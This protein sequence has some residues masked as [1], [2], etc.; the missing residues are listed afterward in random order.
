MKITFLIQDL[1][2]QGAQY[3][4]ALMIR[5]FAAKGYDVDLIVSKVHADLLAKGDIQP[6]EVPLSTNIITLADRKARNNIGEIRNYLKT[7]DSIAVVSMSSNYNAAL[8]IAG[9]GLRHRPKLAYVEHLGM[10]D[11]KSPSYFSLKFWKAKFFNSCFDTIMAVSSGTA[12]LV[13]KS[14]RM[15][16]GEVKVVYNPAIDI[17]YYKKREK[18]AYH[19]WLKDK[20][21]PTFIAAGSHSAIKNHQFLFEAIKLANESTP[22]RL[23]LFGKGELTSQY[24]QWIKS[25]GMEDRI[26]L[27]G[28]TSQLPAE[29]K[30]SDG[31]IISSNLESFSVVL[32]EALAANVPVIS[33]AC[34][35][36]P[37]ELLKNG[38]YGRLVPVGDVKALAA[39]II[40]QI[41]NP[42]SPAPAKA[43]QPYLLEN[44][45]SAYENALNI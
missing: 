41:K 18:E 17:D 20:S 42:R 26:N 28:H 44:V 10:P 36:G 19:H 13:E 21:I 15:K 9:T 45:V 5:G 4:T 3:V 22:V 12:H 32:V 8:A 40:D 11:C 31:L 33:T 14:A 6:F 37:P 25:T 34:P 27:A 35:F 16:M 43:W 2:Q 39:A 23:I 1:F 7:T 30:A 29:L 24:Q 38:E